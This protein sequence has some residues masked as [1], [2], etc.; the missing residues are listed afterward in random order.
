MF[1][2]DVVLLNTSQASMCDL[3][4]AKRMAE[5]LLACCNADL[6]ASVSNLS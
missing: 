3:T 4:E 6:I 5:S 2:L 1:Y